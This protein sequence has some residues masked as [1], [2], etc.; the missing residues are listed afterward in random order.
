MSM[1]VYSIAFRKDADPGNAP[2]MMVRSKKRG[3]W[4]MPGGRVE[5]GEG[6]LEAAVREFLEE[7]GLRLET[8]ENMCI[9]YEGGRVFCGTFSEGTPSPRCDDVFEAREFSELPE[10]LAFPFVEYAPMIEVC[11]TMFRNTVT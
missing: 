5:V 10:D 3:A 8:G 2:F 9:E 7:T 1:W 6:P 11:R 4:E